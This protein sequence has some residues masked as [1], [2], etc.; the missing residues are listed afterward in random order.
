MK[1]IN[2]C[3]NENIAGRGFFSFFNQVLHGLDHSDMRSEELYVDFNKGFFYGKWE[4][5]FSSPLPFHERETEGNIVRAVWFE[6]GMGF[7]DFFPSMEK[8]ERANF[9][10][11]KYIKLNP[12]FLSFYSGHNFETCLS[13]SLG[14][15]VRQ[16]DHGLH[17]ELLPISYY[18]E[19]VR[20]CNKAYKYIYLATDS[21]KAITEFEK[22][23]PD[24]ILYI[25]GMARSSNEVPVQLMGINPLRAGREVLTD[26][27][28]LS[29]CE[30]FFKTASNVSNSVLYFNPRLHY[31][32]I[33]LHIKYS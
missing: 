22:A 20:E 30:F 17:G 4:D 21:E 7:S 23:F 10:I 18:I 5:Y 6:N 29:K 3:I 14:I 27:L 9:L 28:N 19:K 2:V 12:D 16:T 1:N 24:K 8:I 33:D 11:K 25:K 32:N 26:V 15:H 13:S 31:E